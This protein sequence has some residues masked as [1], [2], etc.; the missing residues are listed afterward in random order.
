MTI[1]TIAPAVREGSHILLSLTGPSGSGKTYTGIKVAR[2]LVGERGKIGFLDSETGRGRLYAG[3]DRYLYAELTPPFSPAR[4]IQAID[5]FEAAGV[6]VLIIDTA[7]HEWEG[8]GGVHDLAEANGKKGLLK[9]AAPKAQHKRFVNRLLMSRMHIITCLRAREKFTS[10]RDP[11]SGKE[12]ILNSGFHEIQERGFIFEQTVS[13]LL[14]PGGRKV[15]TKCP[16]DLVPTFGTVGVE[17]EGYLSEKT[18]QAVAAWVAG[19]EA[20]D[21]GWE[22]VRIMARDEAEHGTSRYRDFFAHLSKSDQ[23]RLAAT[24]HENLKSIAQEADALAAA[25]SAAEDDD[26]DFPGDRHGG[27]N[28]DGFGTA[29]E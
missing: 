19:G 17:T 29:A 2:G 21:H 14:L 11:D 7:S 25:R 9:W 26:D 27:V 13:V 23:K 15:V 5:E 20:I 8:I 24:D 28:R 16:E 12:V 3:I 4:F 6:G 22:K 1:L 18:G 10:T